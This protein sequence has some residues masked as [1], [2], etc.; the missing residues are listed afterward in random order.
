MK[1]PMPDNP[2]NWLPYILV[3]DVAASTEK[4]KSLER[5]LLRMSRRCQAWDGSV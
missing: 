2:D 4:A 1:N 5:L 3:D